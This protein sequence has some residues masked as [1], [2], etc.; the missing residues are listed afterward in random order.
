MADVPDLVK[1]LVPR[2]DAQH[3][4]NAHHVV[5][6]GFSIFNVLMSDGHTGQKFKVFR[7]LLSNYF[8]SIEAIHK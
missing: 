5:L 7:G 1:L 3:R 6:V 8:S 4:A 2:V